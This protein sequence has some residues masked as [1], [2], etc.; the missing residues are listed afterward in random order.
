MSL[1]G[2]RIALA[3]K[4]GKD[5]IFAPAFAELGASITVPSASQM[6]EPA[7]SFAGPARRNAEIAGISSST[8]VRSVPEPRSTETDFGPTAVT[9]P[10]T[11]SPLRSSTTSS[12]AAAGML[13]PANTTAWMPAVSIGIAA[14][15]GETHFATPST[16]PTPPGMR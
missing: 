14:H 9:I 12:S 13:A 3:T 2:R 6:R 1:S 4:H 11:R 7:R 16:R 10:C 8:T 15:Q 5:A